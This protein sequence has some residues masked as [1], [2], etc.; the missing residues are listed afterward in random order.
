MAPDRD[1][2]APVRDDELRYLRICGTCYA[3]YETGRPDGLDQRCRC[4]P[5]DQE[6]WPGF[7][8][9][10]RAS[11]CACC[12]TEALRSGSR[13]SPYFCHECQLLAMGVSLWCRRLVFPIGRHSL[14]HT[15][16]PETASPT[17]AAHRGRPRDLAAT[18]HAAA[19]AV[20]RGSEGLRQWSAI[21][22]TRHLQHL[23]LP[24]GTFLSDY[25][26]AVRERGTEPGRCA[27]FAEL[28]ERFSVSARRRPR[29]SAAGGAHGA[30][31]RLQRADRAFRQQN[32]GKDR[33]H[34]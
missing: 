32:Q 19:T 14:M 23:G 10:E 33:S 16:V 11:L 1:G 30:V 18:V 34:E 17:L 7:D 21:I 29:K 6:P 8:F 25:L 27:A 28:C 4:G 31:P 15:W 22:T 26:S 5:S 2:T 9:N 3:L 13:W 24:G 20:S 12:G